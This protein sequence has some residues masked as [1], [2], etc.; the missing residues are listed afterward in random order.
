MLPRLSLTPR[1]KVQL[2]ATFR[3]SVRVLARKQVV[4][5]ADDGGDRLRELKRAVSLSS[6][7]SRIGH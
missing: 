2:V 5:N 3:Y 6:D 7:V 4:E 1:N